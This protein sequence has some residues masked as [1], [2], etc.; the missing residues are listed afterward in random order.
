M[1]LDTWS[2]IN[3]TNEGNIT[4]ENTFLGKT[5]S[6]S[7][8]VG[9]TFSQNNHPSFLIGTLN[10]TQNSC[11]STNAY[12]NTGQDTSRFYQILLADLQGDIVYTTLIDEN[13]AGFDG[14]TFDFELLVGENGNETQEAATTTYYFYIELS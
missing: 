7:D 9:G 2:A 14:R 13:Q 10:M 8:S 3:C 1:C 6:E 12:A 5:A 11:N 4:A